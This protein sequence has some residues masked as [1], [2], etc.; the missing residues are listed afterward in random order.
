MNTA[1]RLEQAAPTDEILLGELTYR[2]VRDAVDVE[3]VPA[4]ELKGKAGHI[5]A[6]RLL[7]IHGD[8]G[9]RRRHD[10]PLIG[11]EAELSELQRSL[12]AAIER[13]PTSTRYRGGRRSA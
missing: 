8:E 10:L 13:W 11:R 2:L 1:A 9:R 5:P 12:E 7:A 4:L 3:P 6:W